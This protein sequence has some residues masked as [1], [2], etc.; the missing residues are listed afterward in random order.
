MTRLH[1]DVLK[2][3][4]PTEVV[5]AS[6]LESGGWYAA[7]GQSYLDGQTSQSREFDVRGYRDVRGRF[8]NDPYHF[9]VY[10]VIECK[11]SAKP[12]VI[13]TH[14]NS[15][16]KGHGKDLGAFIHHPVAHHE[17]F[18]GRGSSSKDVALTN[19]TL[20]AYHHYFDSARWGHN[21][22]EAF[23]S[24]ETA[25]HS[26]QIYTAINLVVNATRFLVSTFGNPADEWKPVFYPV[27]VVDG[28]LFEAVVK[29]P[30]AVELEEKKHIILRHRLSLPPT[31]Q[32]L[33]DR[34]QQTYLIDFVQLDFVESYAREVYR[35]HLDLLDSANRNARAASETGN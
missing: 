16:E 30:T 5:T 22:Y 21:Y 34:E 18:W 10:L 20:R 8:P 35:S 24:R 9:G 14:D 2:T 4:F 1:E 7:L 33:H 13:F 19:D 31:R 32:S 26:T 29:S 6:T 12:W 25:D 23:R 15:G 17:R 27:I 11:K 3:G 28:R